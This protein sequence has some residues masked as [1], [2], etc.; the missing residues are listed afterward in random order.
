VGYIKDFSLKVKSGEF[1]IQTIHKLPDATIIGELTAIRGIGR[2]TAEMVMLFGLQRP[3]I[4]SF[5]DLGIRRG[6]Q[7]LYSLSNID[8]EQ[9]A[10]YAKRYSP[11]GSVASL[12]LWAIAGGAIPD[13]L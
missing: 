7:I 2:W 1:D 9:Y 12:Y 10:K 5:G 3:D 8:H 13:G 11:H 4:V 6:M